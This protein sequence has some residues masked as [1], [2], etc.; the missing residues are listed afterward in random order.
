MDTPKKIIPKTQ[1]SESIW[2]EDCD[3]TIKLTL[4]DKDGAVLF[5]MFISPAAR[6]GLAEFLDQLR[7]REHE[8]IAEVAKTVTKELKAKKG[9]AKPAPPDASTLQKVLGKWK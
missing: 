4:E 8:A 1:I 7:A 2:L 5:S 9:K 3:G 6:S